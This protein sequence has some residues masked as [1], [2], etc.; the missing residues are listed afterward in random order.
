MTYVVLPTF[1]VVF[2]FQQEP[3]A[4]KSPLVGEVCFDAGLRRRSVLPI[5]S[6]KHSSSWLWKWSC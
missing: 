5:C 3:L 2:Q 4:P 6:L 1:G